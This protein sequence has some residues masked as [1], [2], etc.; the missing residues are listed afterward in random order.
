[1]QSIKSLC[2]F[3]GSSAKGNK[4]HHQEAR[5]LGMILAQ[6]DISLV[7]GGAQV[8]L[9]QMVADST[10]E[11]NG[12]VIG[13]IPEHLVKVE[14]KHTGI[15]EIIVVESMHE[16]KQMMFDK[17][18]AIV[19]LP[20]GFGTLDETFEVLTW[21]QLHLH[22]KPVIVVNS[23]GYWNPFKQLAQYV[24]KEGYAHESHLDLMT[25]VDSTDEILPALQKI[26][27]PRP[28]VNVKWI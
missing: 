24:V 20:G 21:K 23:G 9:M 22:D 15:T 8:G 5:N 1:M 12:K 13:I 3:C 7:Y 25:F 14:G 19:V 4:L 27:D 6:N 18:D 16:R 17:S 26:P 2:V 28:P 10:M 11:N